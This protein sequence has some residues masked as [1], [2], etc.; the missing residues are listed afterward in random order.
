MGSAAAQLGPEYAKAIREL[1][2]RSPYTGDHYTLTQSMAATCMLD[3]SVTVDRCRLS[4][5]YTARIMLDTIGRF[6]CND[7]VVVER[8]DSI[9]KYYS[10]IWLQLNLNYTLFQ[11][12]L[13]ERQRKVP[14]ERWQAAV[15]YAIYRDLKQPKL[16]NRH[17]MYQLDNR[18]VEYEEPLPRFD[19]S[20][21]PEMKTIEGYRCQKA[22]ALYGGRLWTVWFTSEI[23]MDG[24]LWKFNGLPGLILEAF[25]AQDYFHFS[26][27]RIE[28]PERPIVYYRIK[29]KQVT[30]QA[31]REMARKLCLHPFPSETDG[32][33][34]PDPQ[35]GKLGWLPDDWQIPYNPIERE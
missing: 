28:Q 12:C 31:F 6:K 3:D 29:T 13:E 23:P 2:R 4:V 27:Q 14:K 10:R 30:R 18:I 22:Q 25:D 21:L 1:K 33:A 26:V 20:L 15:D 17:M 19:W 35:T 11:Q 7:L 34:V 9:Q 24:G 16:I 32:I 8:G 5:T